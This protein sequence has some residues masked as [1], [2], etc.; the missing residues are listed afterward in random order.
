MTNKDYYGGDIP[1]IRSGELNCAK[2]ALSLTRLG[3]ENSSAKIVEKGTILY[4]LYGATSGEVGLAGVEVAIN[5]AIL[6]IIPR[7]ICDKMFL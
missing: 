5:Q 6:A 4:A 1:F 3:L 7:D 2:T